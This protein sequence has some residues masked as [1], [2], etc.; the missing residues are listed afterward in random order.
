[1]TTAVGLEL[2]RLHALGKSGRAAA[3]KAMR[4]RRQASPMPAASRRGQSRNTRAVPELDAGAGR[5]DATAIAVSN[6]APID[7]GVAD[8]V[9]SLRS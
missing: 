5:E 1:M 3:L 8:T 9:Q 2:A 7:V 4:Q 6:L